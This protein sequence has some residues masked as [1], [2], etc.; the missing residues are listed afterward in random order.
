[1]PGDMFLHV[2]RG[3]EWSVDGFLGLVRRHRRLG[4]TIHVVFRH[5]RTT[6]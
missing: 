4:V 2:W 6:I 3:V 1:M 5:K